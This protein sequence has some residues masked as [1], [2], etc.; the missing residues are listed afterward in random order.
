MTTKPNPMPGN[1]KCK[2]CGKSVIWYVDL[3]CDPEL[4]GWKHIES[5]GHFLW[6]CNDCNMLNRADVDMSQVQKP[7]TVVNV[8]KKSPNYGDSQYIGHKCYY[9]NEDIEKLLSGEWKGHWRHSDYQD[10]W[11]K[12]NLFSCR[13]SNTFDG[14]WH[15]ADCKA[16]PNPNSPIKVTKET[17]IVTTQV[18][19]VTYTVQVSDKLS[20]PENKG[21]KFRTE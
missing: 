6:M 4:V 14:E 16:S 9:C 1:P 17:K 11:A 5:N 13:S 3:N 12:S 15:V 2:H 20:V 7:L 8:S 18:K 10:N 21:R 19:T